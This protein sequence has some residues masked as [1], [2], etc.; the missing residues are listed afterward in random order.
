M[1]RATKTS[2]IGSRVFVAYSL[3][4]RMKERIDTQM[5]ETSSVDTQVIGTKTVHM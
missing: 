2:R 5:N 1:M 3:I 4:V